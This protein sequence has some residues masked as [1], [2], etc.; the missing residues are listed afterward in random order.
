M[1]TNLSWVAAKVVNGPLDPLEG[2][3]D[4]GEAVIS[5]QAARPV[6]QE[7]CDK[8]LYFSTITTIIHIH[9]Q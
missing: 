1:Q 8:I 3:E 7:A 9:K 6:A 5:R 2:E 4:V